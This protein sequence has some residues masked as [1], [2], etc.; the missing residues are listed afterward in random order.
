LVSQLNDVYRPFGEAP[1]RSFLERQSLCSLALALLLL[2][3]TTTAVP[4]FLLIPALW[5]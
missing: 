5:F 1:W 4:L 2:L 3:S